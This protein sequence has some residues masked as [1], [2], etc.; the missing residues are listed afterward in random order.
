MRQLILAALLAAMV[1]AVTFFIKIPTHNGYIHPG[2]AV[3]YLAACLL[4]T[5]LAMLTGALGG[6]L[7]DAA[8]G[9]VIYMLP[10]FIIKA[11]LVPAFTAGQDKI[12]TKRN[13]I[14]S[15]IGLPITIGGYYIAEAVILSLTSTVSF[16]QFTSYFFSAAP[17]VSAVYSLAGNLV[18]AA[19]SMA[20]FIVVALALDKINIKSRIRRS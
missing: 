19:A 12:L 6:M 9:Y 1:A 14:A 18:Q 3:I 17:W 15:A 2:D 4:P 11:L 20:I 13:I 10:T 16:S 8:G 5:P 7:A